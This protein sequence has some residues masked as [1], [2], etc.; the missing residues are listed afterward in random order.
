MRT[1]NAGGREYGEEFSLQAKETNLT[2]TALNN[3][4]QT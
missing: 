4:V 2:G 1:E 3:A